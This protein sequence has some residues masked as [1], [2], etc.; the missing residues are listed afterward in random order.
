MTCRPL[1]CLFACLELNAKK[2]SCSLTQL[3]N[4]SRYSQE[5]IW[6]LHKIGAKEEMSSGRMSSRVRSAIKHCDGCVSI[7]DISVNSQHLVYFM[8]SKLVYAVATCSCVFLVYP[9][10]E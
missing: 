5:S 2:T 8:V 3:C 4:L 1:V 7:Y 10:T 6:P 9:I